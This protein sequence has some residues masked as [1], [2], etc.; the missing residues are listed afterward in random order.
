MAEELSW[1]ET[2]TTNLS[3][4]Y[5]FTHSLTKV[6]CLPSAQIARRHSLSLDSAIRLASSQTGRSH[7]GRKAVPVAPSLS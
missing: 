1:H 2:H 4:L 3:F 6:V 5:E 7:G